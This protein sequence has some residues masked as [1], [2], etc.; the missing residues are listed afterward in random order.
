MIDDKIN[1]AVLAIS[2]SERRGIK[3]RNVEFAELKE[4]FGIIHDAHAGQWHRQVSLLAVESM[5]KIKEKGLNVK[6]GDF[7]EN[8]CMEGLDI[9]QIKIGTKIKI[10]E[11]SLPEFSQIGKDCHQRCHIYYSVGDCV[12]PREG[13]FARVL[14]GGTIKPQDKI[15]LINQEQFLNLL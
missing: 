14:K 12:M 10:G 8:I 9:A 7:A 15:C 11:D 2:I 1:G 5:Q 3:K 4:D 13:I 6:P